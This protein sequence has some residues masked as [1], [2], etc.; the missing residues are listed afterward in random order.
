MVYDFMT[1]VLQT[2][3]GIVGAAILVFGFAFLIFLGD[4][5]ARNRTVV[6]ARF[7]TLAMLVIYASWFGLLWWFGFSRSMLVVACLA[8]TMLCIVFAASYRRTMS[9][10]SSIPSDQ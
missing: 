4:A 2:L 9:T 1:V 6:S 10:R 5:S 7:D 8:T 3:G